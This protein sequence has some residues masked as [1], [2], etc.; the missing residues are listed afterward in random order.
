[1]VD[2]TKVKKVTQNLDKL[3]KED[4]LPVGIS[5]ANLPTPEFIAAVNRI[6][7]KKVQT[8]PPLPNQPSTVN[9]VTPQPQNTPDKAPEL[10][11]K[12]EGACSTCHTP[13]ATLMLN[14]GKLL[15]SVAYCSVCRKDVAQKTVKPLGR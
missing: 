9:T 1:M 4:L 11:Y 7:A 13:V 15:V 6:E 3:T 8:I 2:A 14:V 12:W 5:P 10:T